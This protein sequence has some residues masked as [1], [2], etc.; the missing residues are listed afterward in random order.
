MQSELLIVGVDVAKDELQL[1]AHGPGTVSR[2]LPNQAQAIQDWLATLAKGSIVAMEATGKYHGLLAELAHAAGMRVYVLNARDVYFYA[3]ALGTRGKTDRLDAQVIA[4]YAAEHHAEL[5]AWSPAPAV[6]EQLQQMLKRR[7]VLTDQRVA[8]RLSLRGMA[9]LQSVNDLLE[10]A[11]ASALDELD[12]KVLALVD[13]D[14]KLHEDVARLQTITGFGMQ[15]SVL[16][17]A[18]FNRIDFGNADA[19]V[20][21]SGL[22]PRPSDSGTKHGKRRLSKRG[23]SILRR[24]MYLAAF[25]ASHSKA[26]GSLYKSLRAKGFAATQALIILARKLLRVAWAVWRTGKAFDAS[27]IGAQNACVKT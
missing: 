4:R 2:R 20:A 7:K 11:F 19:V 1:A 25:A 18:L 23:P 15:A 3:K 6:L 10:Q 21:Y 12:A 14:R 13:S 9:S 8:M 27:Q 26:L 17:A 5:R 22:D 24:M 16:L